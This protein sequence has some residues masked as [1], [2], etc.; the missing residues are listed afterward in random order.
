MSGMNDS[1]VPQIHESDNTF[2]LNFLYVLWPSV[3]RMKSVTQLWIALTKE[4]GP[5]LIGEKKR[6]ENICRRYGIHLGKPGRPQ[7][8]RQMARD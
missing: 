4:F 2:I 7:K 5:Q 3:E 6:I 1:C 8:H